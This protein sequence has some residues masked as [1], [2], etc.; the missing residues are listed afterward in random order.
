MPI[1]ENQVVTLEYRVTNTEGQMVDEGRAPLVYLHGGKDL[2]PTLQAG[3]AGKDVGDDVSVHL[4]PA[5]AFGEYD[6]DLVV[7]EQRS[8]FPAEIEPGMQFEGTVD[9]EQT[10][11]FTITEIEDERVVL[12]GNHPLAG[13][14]L[15]FSMKVSAVRPATAEEIAA[16]AA[17][18]Q[19]G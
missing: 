10:Q 3:L 11:L 5:Q 6:D 13:L 12:D 19:A 7:V 18:R 4:T 9:G 8:S 15:I 2:F 16:G 14:D 17:A 1:A